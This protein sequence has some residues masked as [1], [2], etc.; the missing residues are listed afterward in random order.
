ME[1]RL[2]PDRSAPGLTRSVGPVV[3]NMGKSASQDGKKE[4]RRSLEE[5]TLLVATHDESLHRLIS[6]SIVH[7][8]RR[9]LS[10]R[11]GDEAMWILRKIQSTPEQDCLMVVSDLFLPKL[12]GLALCRFVRSQPRL[13]NSPYLMVAGGEDPD[14]CVRSLDAGADDF[15]KRPFGLREFES[16]IGALHRR[17]ERD[18][19][20]S[21][22]FPFDRVDSG[23]FV[24]DTQRFEVR[25]HGK[26]V[27]LSH[28]EFQICVVLVSRLD[29]VVPYEEL[30]R[31][32][33]GEYYEVGRENLKVHI[34]SLKKKLDG[35]PAIEAVRGFGYRMKDL[36]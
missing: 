4:R 6:R 8:V 26:I 33:W 12:D 5:R 34:H 14:L 13:S 7:A 10:A 35:G 18:E 16:R 17:A 23:T 21:A 31:A 1:N 29:M 28:K 25:L 2:S 19:R 20:N 9:V 15:L 36:Q 30:F 22:G 24:V 27:P 11:D 32:V 3:T